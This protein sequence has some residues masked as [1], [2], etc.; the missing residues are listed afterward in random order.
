MLAGPS[1]AVSAACAPICGGALARYG[2]GRVSVT[3]S[4]WA[5]TVVATG[6]YSRQLLPLRSRRSGTARGRPVSPAGLAYLTYEE[7]EC[8]RSWLAELGHKA[9]ADE[10]GQDADR[11]M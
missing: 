8:L 4:A 11:Y 6:N 7:I 2:D 1:A 10:R 3:E 5:Q 9:W